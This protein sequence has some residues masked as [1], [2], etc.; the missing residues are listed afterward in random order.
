MIVWEKNSYN[1]EEI[2]LLYSLWP[3]SLVIKRSLDIWEN[4]FGISGI[5]HIKFD[6]GQVS[7]VLYG[8]S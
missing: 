7:Q 4:W 5:D 1:G 3:F 2:G 8:Q 6:C